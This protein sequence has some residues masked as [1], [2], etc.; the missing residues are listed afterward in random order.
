[1]EPKQILLWVIIGIVAILVI[2]VFISGLLGTTWAYS[3]CKYTLKGIIDVVTF[4]FTKG[5]EQGGGTNPAE[6]ICSPLKG[7]GI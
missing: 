7:I 2:V 1:M 5:W 6:V 3:M 4:G